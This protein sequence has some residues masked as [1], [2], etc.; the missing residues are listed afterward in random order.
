MSLEDIEALSFKIVDK[1]AGQ[2]NFAPGEWSIV[3]R[4]IHTSA[5]FEYM[6]T[7]R[8]HP[9][10]VRV[11]LDAIRTGKIIITD[12]EMAM[13]GIRKNKLGSYGSCV[14]CFI[15]DPGVKKRAEESGTTRAHAAVDIAA[16]LMDGGICVI[17]NAPTALFRLIELVKE[18]KAHPA[19]VV[20]LPV[21]FVNAAES[22]EALIHMDIPYI[23]NTGR[24][25]GSNIAASVINALIILAINN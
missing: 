5:D 14:K 24:K 20:G 2:H 8:F 3:R 10:A 4:I 11:G 16:P 25:G 15:S 1:E 22:K 13:A 12:T 6:K 19:L 9:H 7:I 18:K 23:S 17:G 21:G